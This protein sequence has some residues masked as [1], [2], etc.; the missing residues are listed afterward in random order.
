M[1]EGKKLFHKL[2]LKGQSEGKKQEGLIF[3]FFFSTPSL[4]KKKKK[5]ER[6]SGSTMSFG[7]AEQTGAAVSLA[8]GHIVDIQLRLRPRLKSRPAPPFHSTVFLPSFLS[9]G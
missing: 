1:K 9:V 6:D 8:L 4:E 2:L 3:L 7:G 5:E